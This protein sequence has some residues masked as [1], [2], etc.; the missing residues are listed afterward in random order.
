[1]DQRILD[2]IKNNRVTAF[3]TMLKD[4]MPHSAALH[5]SFNGDTQEFYI[6]TSSD[7][8]KCELLKEAGTCKASA[9]IGLSEE[10]WITLQMEG[11]AEIINDPAE[12]TFV[13]NIHYAMHP[14]SAKFKDDPLTIFF[15]FKPTWYRYTDFNNHPPLELYN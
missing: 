1:M 11:I 8:R 3:T 6:S 15:K 9:V 12:I 7:T 2:F 5:Y 10:E 13:Q 14:N 4:G